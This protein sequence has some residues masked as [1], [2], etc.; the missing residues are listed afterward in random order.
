[1]PPYTASRRR[2]PAA[3]RKGRLAGSLS[4]HAKDLHEFQGFVD[5]RNIG[6][7][8][9]EVRLRSTRGARL[10][11]AHAAARRVEALAV[12]RVRALRAR[13]VRAA[14]KGVELWTATA[15]AHV[16]REARDA[17]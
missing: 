4:W 17:S 13:Y 3:F 1:M 14:V 9:I 6:A 7:A 15:R 16:A 12:R 5:D 2:A 11:G 10:R 8:G